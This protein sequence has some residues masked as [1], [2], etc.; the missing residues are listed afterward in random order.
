MSGGL[1]ASIA[2]TNFCSRSPNVAQS[3]SSWT[4][5]SFAQVSTCRARISLPAVTYDLKSHTR[6]FG[7]LCAD[8]MRRSTCN[9]A[10]VPPVTTA[11]R[12]KNSRRAMTPAARGGEVADVEVERGL[13]HAA[14]G[15]G[16]D[17]GERAA[18]GRVHERRVDA[19]V[20]AR[21]GRVAQLVA[22][23]D[24]QTGPALA[25]LRDIDPQV[26]PEAI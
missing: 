9:P 5:R 16:I 22:D 20:H 10:A 8:A 18:D 21:A 3:I 11:A 13:P 2:A 12:R 7:P 25:D 4:L 23:V 17:R 14:A 24:A 6:S 15:L 1:P 26:L 19:T